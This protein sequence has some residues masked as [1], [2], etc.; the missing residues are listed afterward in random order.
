MFFYTYT[1][2]HTTHTTMSKPTSPT[3]PTAPI[4]PDES[5][6]QGLF[7]V[8]LFCETRGGETVPDGAIGIFHTRED[9]IAAIPKHRAIAP[10]GANLWSI[11]GGAYGVFRLEVGIMHEHDYHTCWP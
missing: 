11:S 6:E 4:E 8:M 2:P 10:P 9:A 5:D 1:W 7:V 3:S